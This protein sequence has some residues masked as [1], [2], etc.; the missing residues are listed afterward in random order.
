MS[1][2]TKNFFANNP[3]KTLALLLVL[4]FVGC[5]LLAGLVVCRKIVGTPDAYYHHDLPANFRGP[6][7]WGKEPYLLI[8]NA[9]GF[10]SQTEG[11]VAK[12][13]AQTRILFLGDSFTEGVGTIYEKTFVGRFAQTVSV[14]GYDVLNAA[15]IS[16]SPKLY[17]LKTRYLLDIVGLKFDQLIVFVDLSDVHDEIGYESFV[18]AEDFE[19][20]PFYLV[21]KMDS[22]LRSYSASYWTLRKIIL[23]KIDVN[24]EK[25][26]RKYLAKDQEIAD[27]WDIETELWASNDEVYARWGHYG[28]ALAKENM[29][30]LYDLCKTH[31]IEMSMVIYPWPNEI[32]QGSLDNRNVAAWTEFCREKNIPLL[33][34]YPAFINNGSSEHMVNQYYIENDKH[35]N[36]DGHK[37]VSELLLDWW[38]TIRPH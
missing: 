38:R 22:L 1:E 36:E 10:R 28:L 26:D 5:D 32:M 2:E 9:L 15:V 20:S 3:R 25:T 23:P 19:L 35:W 7:D 34:L 24:L 30:H 33:N 27:N 29:E 14:E 6:R 16:Y 18:P 8:T 21:N 31:N 17:Y 13:S 4:A 37:L 11:A 12:T